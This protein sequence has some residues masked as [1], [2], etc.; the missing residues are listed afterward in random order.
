M[1][2][3]KKKEKKFL[4]PNFGIR[5][6]KEAFIENLTMLLSSGLNTTSTLRSIEEEIKSKRLKRIVRGISN[7]IEEGYPLWKSLKR[8]DIFDQS[9]I[10]L[11]KVGEESGRLSENLKIVS[12]QTQKNKG[13]R[14][15]LRS[16]LMYPIFVLVLASVIGI[17]IAWFILPNLAKIFNNMDI[18]LPVITQFMINLGVFLGDYGIYVVPA[19]VLIIL[20][21]FYFVFL[22]KKT[23]YIGQA[24]TLSIP[25]IKKLLKELEIA[26]F[27]YLLG[28]LLD[29]GLPVSNA[30]DSLISGSKN[31]LF[32]YQKFY[33]H[34][35][36]N[37]ENGLSFKKSIDSY[38]KVDRLFPRSVQQMIVAAEQSGKL[39][40]ILLKISKSYSEIV[41]STT[42]NFMTALEPIMLIIVWLAVVFIALSIILP[43]YS[44]V[45]NFN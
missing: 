4:F 32:R 8:S 37:V 24:I 3:K 42:K 16:A 43:I 12:E 25:G 29:A 1:A 31:G 26:R 14:S 17:G 34:L 20:T 13:F 9:N 5:K 22:H 45:G 40:E 39:S 27:T 2:K 19:A 36:I 6:E 10:S 28:I 30:L 38:N 41:E 15:K 7:D 11:I 23:K 21:I 44:L 18:E 33:K 35:K